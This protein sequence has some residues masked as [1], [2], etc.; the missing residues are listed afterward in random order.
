MEGPIRDGIVHA[1]APVARPN[2]IGAPPPVVVPDVQ[3]KKYVG[4]K[5]PALGGV[6]V[7]HGGR[8]SD[9]AIANILNL[10]EAE[11]MHCN[12]GL[13]AARHWTRIRIEH[14]KQMYVEFRRANTHIKVKIKS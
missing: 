10:Y 7:H 9:A 5:K 12:M 1:V 8:W 6:D 11:W 4:R 3:P 13:L 14:T 2:V